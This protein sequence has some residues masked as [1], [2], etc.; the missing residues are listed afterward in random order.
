MGCKLKKLIND[1]TIVCQ[2][3]DTDIELGGIKNCSFFGVTD[4]DNDNYII[5]KY[6]TETTYEANKRPKNFCC[7]SVF[8]ITYR[9]PW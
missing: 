9:N 2:N 7:Y 5:A 3:K 4:N 6:G 1:N 8:D